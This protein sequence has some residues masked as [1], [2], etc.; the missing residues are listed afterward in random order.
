MKLNRVPAIQCGVWAL[1]LAVWV[2]PAFA[3]APGADSVLPPELVVPKTPDLGRQA[4]LLE[5]ILGAAAAEKPGSGG[6]G[7]LLTGLKSLF[8]PRPQ[9]IVIPAEELR[10]NAEPLR[11]SQIEVHGVLAVEGDDLAFA[12]SRGNIG[13]DLGGGAKPTGFP[14]EDRAWMPAKA[15][16]LLEMPFG[17]PVLRV[18]AL[19]P[20]VPL[21]S[22][23]LARVLE[24]QG[25]IREAVEAYDKA[26]TE[27]RKAPLPW[28]A[29]ASTEA[30]WLAYN[31]L[32]DSKSANKHL[33]NAWTLYA[34]V[35]KKGEP[36]FDTWVPSPEGKNWT[37]MPVA[38]AVGPLLDSVGRESFWYRLVDFFV[39]LGGGS[40]A[41]GVVLLAL[42]TRLGIH[43][44]T[45]KQLASM[46]AMRKLQPQIKALQEEF[47]D[48]KQ[49]FQQEMW[50]VWQENGVNPLGGCWPMLIQ[51]PILIFVY[52]GI[53]RYIVQ[54]A[55]SGFLWVRNLAM[56]DLVLLVAYTA[57]MVL[58]QK[59]ANRMQPM[60]A[61]EKQRQQQ[62]MMTW[63][64]PLMFFFFFKTLPSAFILYWLASNLIYF[65]E[66]WWFRRSAER[67][68][69]ANG[70][71]GVP[72]PPRKR[73]RFMDIMAAAT[74][75]AEKASQPTDT[76]PA[77][78]PDSENPR[79]TQRKRKK[80]RR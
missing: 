43:P 40:A 50:R 80:R 65:G 77:R 44:L 58:F 22:L 62:Q 53:R 9:K 36:L 25:K 73:S 55:G 72:R 27:L 75:R 4:E 3:Q 33:Y 59:M 54:F 18:T 21:A 8:S 38:K 31:R 34:T 52:Q 24:E 26:A 1:L 60:P 23:R 64:M 56:P 14:D 28:A 16:G 19:A 51:M 46:E 15:V 67:D 37:Q 35:D 57:S 12:T 10:A 6:G 49:R 48:D 61:D 70:S 78:K 68:E 39:T 11:G 47:K 7:G 5:Q 45:R 30:G 32:R 42:V 29:F 2:L 71:P 69:P 20:S 41:L 76:A 66:Q 79:P 63:M 74:Q 17:E 13:I